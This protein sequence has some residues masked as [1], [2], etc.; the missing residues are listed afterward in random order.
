MGGDD[1]DRETPLPIPNRV[2][3][4]V[5]AD[6]IANWWESRRLPRKRLNTK[7]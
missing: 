3:K 6:G 1:S 2:V 4:T 7:F 5:C